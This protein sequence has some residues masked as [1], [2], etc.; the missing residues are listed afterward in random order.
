MQSQKGNRVF[1]RYFF[2]SL[3]VFRKG[4]LSV[5]LSNLHFGS[6]IWFG[7]W[8]I[9]TH[10][11]TGRN[12][13]NCQTPDMLIRTLLTTSFTC[14]STNHHL[15]HTHTSFPVLPSKTRDIIFL[16]F[17]LTSRVSIKNQQHHQQSHSLT[18]Q[19]DPFRII[20]LKTEVLQG[21][22]VCFLLAK[23]AGKGRKVRPRTAL[24]WVIFVKPKWLQQ[25]RFFGKVTWYFYLDPP[26]GVKF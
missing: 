21:E 25:I 19:P 6:P 2:D 3:L 17:W 5:F 14:W 12:C 16:K 1:Q 18:D 20:Q 4:N 13:N 11:G 10:L 7:T 15:T 24:R 8:L 26:K 22:C 23:G 9:W